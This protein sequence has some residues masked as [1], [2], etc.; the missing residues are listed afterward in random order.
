MRAP[1]LALALLMLVTG[2]AML[3]NT[4]A[5]DQTWAACESCKATLPPQCQITL[6][7]RDGRYWGSCSDHPGIWDFQRCINAYVR[8]NPL[9]RSPR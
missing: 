4:P 6:V 5:Q 9:P 7:E 2:C 8:A 3:A 1:V